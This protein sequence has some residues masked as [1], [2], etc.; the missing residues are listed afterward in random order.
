M[1][2]FSMFF[3]VIKSVSFVL[4]CSVKLDSSFDVIEGVMLLS[5]VLLVELEPDSTEYFVIKYGFSMDKGTNTK[6][7]EYWELGDK[8]KVFSTFSGTIFQ[9]FAC[10][11]IRE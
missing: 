7:S 11:E 9:T 5:L 2:L 4:M 6:G 3:C 8:P 10:C 1:F